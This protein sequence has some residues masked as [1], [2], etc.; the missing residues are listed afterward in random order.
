MMKEEIL[1]RI[2]WESQVTGKRG[3][4]KAAYGKYDT[5]GICKHFDVIYPDVKHYPIADNEAAIQKF[6][7]GGKNEA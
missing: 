6:L 5:C 2:G 1:Y 7:T 4:R 3:V